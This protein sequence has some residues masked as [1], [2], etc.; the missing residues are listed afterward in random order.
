VQQ[1]R[2][3]LRRRR[4]TAV[5]GSTGALEQPIQELLLKP[6]LAAAFAAAAFAAAA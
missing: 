6:V 3:S 1:L 5:H 4:V 2:L